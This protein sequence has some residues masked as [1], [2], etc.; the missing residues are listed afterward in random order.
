MLKSLHGAAPKSIFVIIEGE[1]MATVRLDVQFG[2]EAAQR[3]I[4]RRC[5][6]EMRAVLDYVW[7]HQWLDE[8]LVHALL[9]QDM[10]P[11]QKF[12]LIDE[13]CEV[14]KSNPSALAN[15]H[16][17]R[18]VV[19]IAERLKAG[20]AW[21]KTAEARKPAALPDV[22][23]AI[24]K[25]VYADIVGKEYPRAVQAAMTLSADMWESIVKHS[26]ATARM[27][28]EAFGVRARANHAGIY[29]MG[30]GHKMPGPL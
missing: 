6:D 8:G 1:Q 17:A 25:T 16:T 2:G 26:A 28:G 5:R 7:A 4:I 3:L 13:E 12:Q 20:D 27:R 10:P 30:A 23:Y 14:L 18:A 19:V 15:L 11:A 29:L 21:C 24:G 22:E 9:S